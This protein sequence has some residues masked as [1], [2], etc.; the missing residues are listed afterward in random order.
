MYAID[1]KNIS[2]FLSST[3]KDMQAERDW[4]KKIVLPKLQDTLY[5]YGINVQVTDLRWGIDTTSERE[6]KKE[7][8]ILH[9]C[10]DAIK[11][12]SLILSACLGIGMAGFRLKNV[13]TMWRVTL[14][15][16]QIVV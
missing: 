10:L 1:K 15:V 4:I 11:E 14:I 16:I 12:I 3:F 9:I 5:L 7:S 8:K 6:D 13:C 2:I